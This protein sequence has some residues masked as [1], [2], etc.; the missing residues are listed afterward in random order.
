MTSQPSCAVLA[1]YNTPLIA[2]GTSER[3]RGMNS[4][5]RIIFKAD[6]KPSYD[7]ERVLVVADKFRCLGYLDPVGVWR[8][9][10]DHEEIKNVSGWVH[11]R[12]ES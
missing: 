4:E 3:I 11:L 8:Y 1:G 2:G 9:D 5:P 7:G 6:E 10:K 12:I